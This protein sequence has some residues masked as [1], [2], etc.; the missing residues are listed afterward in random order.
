M[1]HSTRLI[2]QYGSLP[3]GPDRLAQKLAGTHKSVA[4]LEK[5]AN[6]WLRASA[7]PVQTADQALEALAWAHLLPRLDET[8]P[9]GL[10]DVLLDRL[11]LV[12]GDARAIN[13]HQDPLLRQLLAGELA[14][15]LSCQFPQVRLCRHLRVPARQ[16]LTAG[17]VNLLDGEGLLHARHLELLRPLLACWTR[18]RLLGE[19]IQGGCWSKTA[20]KQYGWLVRNALRL[21][22][23]DGTHV[24]SHGPAHGS[25][26][27]LFAVALRLCDNEDTGKIA[28]LAL[29]QKPAR[30]ATKRGKKFSLP[31]PAMHSEWAAT[32]VLRSSWLRNSDRLTV[33]YPGQSVHIELGVGRQLLC[34]GPW[35]W[36]VECDG[37]PAP[38]TSSWE[39]VCW[40]SDNDVDYLELEIDLTGGLRMQRHILLAREDRFLMLADAIL[41]ERPAALHYRSQLPWCQDISVRGAK[42]TQESYLFAGKKRLA[43]VLPLAL[44]EWGL[45]PVLSVV[46]TGDAETGTV[47]LPSATHI[48]SP[49]LQQ[50][51]RGCRMFAPLWIDL[52]PRRIA[53]RLTWRQ[54]TVGDAMHAQ[55]ADVAVGY[56]VAVGKQQ[57]L[58]YRSL[59]KPGN[60]T[61]LG[62]N[63]STEFLVARFKDGGEVES[64][65]EVE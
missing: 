51:A 13:L 11:L 61:V 56:R 65:M 30:P 5:A 24:F 52:D 33:L 27:A 4:A 53:R 32:G 8:L 36:E 40:V 59:A 41:G 1:S 58:V 19:S 60:R 43:M 64:L 10:R 39:A 34:S 44:S 2:A 14:L 45:S 21:T 62:H 7:G 42:E 16:A 63:L 57:W 31:I 48:A 18:C 29:L 9:Q 46:S 22:R 26:A 12:A 38:P 6:Q 49:T 25:D 50:A 54:L 20:E 55:P 23:Y 28:R 3:D 47:P 37:V 15:V 35:Q 17:L